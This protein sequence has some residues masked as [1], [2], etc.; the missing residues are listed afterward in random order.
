ML[1]TRRVT[2]RCAPRVTLSEH[3]IKL[4]AQHRV[5]PEHDRQGFPKRARHT[6]QS[7]GYI[8]SLPRM[9]SNY[10][11]HQTDVEQRITT[12]YLCQR[13][14]KCFDVYAKRAINIIGT[15]NHISPQAK[16]NTQTACQA[17]RS[18]NIHQNINPT[19]Q[20]KYIHS[21]TKKLRPNTS[22]NHYRATQNKTDNS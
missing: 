1:Q 11:Q 2:H 12:H 15:Y 4:H 21:I 9:S 18:I 3:I 14:Y 16:L 17:T 20:G 10:T 13:K 22:M 8:L 7:A 5:A 6:C 19:I